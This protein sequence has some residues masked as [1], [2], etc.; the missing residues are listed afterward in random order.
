MD[1][2]DPHQRYSVDFFCGLSS[3][4]ITTL[5]TH[6]VNKLIYRQILEGGAL[7]DSLTRLRLEGLHYLYRGA[8]PPMFQKAVSLS[9]MFGVYNV[10][11]VPMKKLHMAP[12][13]E[14]FAA[15][16]IAGTAETIFCPFERVQV[17]LIKS[18]YHSRFKNMFHTFI[19]LR[20]THG[21]LEY[22]RGTAV[23]YWKNTLSCSMF[24][25]MKAE[26]KKHYGKEDASVTKNLLNFLTG[27]VLGAAMTT[28]L[29][30]YK[31]VQ[32]YIQKDIGG[33]FLTSREV[34]LSIYSKG[35]VKLFYK[36]VVLNSIRALLGW[37]V[38]N[39]VF[40]Y[41]KEKLNRL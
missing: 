31:T 38:T 33:R 5:V 9:T 22:Y 30:P 8:L 35:G 7:K 4:V 41:M 21:I 15:G 20:R 25:V 37:G 26:V 2:R 29:Y 6:P 16:F 27:G 17:L 13:T 11:L 1:H 40:D 10:A 12:R 39:S 36:G 3:A 18:E 32:V 24:F 19:D 14:H 34:I 23:V 28:V